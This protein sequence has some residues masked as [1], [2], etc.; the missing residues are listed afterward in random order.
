MTIDASKQEERRKIDVQARQAN[1]LIGKLNVDVSDAETFLTGSPEFR[2]SAGTYERLNSARKKADLVL[3]ER[4]LVDGR[5]G[6]D[7]MQR[8]WEVRQ[9]LFRS[10]ND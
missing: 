1:D 3:W 4:T 7:L 9:E 6:A 10:P 2:L 8:V 5:N